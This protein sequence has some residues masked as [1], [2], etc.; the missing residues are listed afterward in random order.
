M[1]I[2][3]G[4]IEI[5]GQGEPRPTRIRYRGPR[6]VI[7]GGY[8]GALRVARATRPPVPAAPASPREG[9]ALTALL[10]LAGLRLT[11][12]LVAGVAVLGLAVTLALMPEPKHISLE[13]LTELPFRADHTSFRHR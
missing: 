7:A 6:A 8:A 2:P 13:E 11:S 1:R 4:F 5:R 10:P 12:A 3:G 9:N